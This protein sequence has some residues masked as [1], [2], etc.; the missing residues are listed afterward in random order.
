ML[1]ESF[2]GLQ[3]VIK[4]VCM[5]YFGHD[6]ED[7]GWGF[8]LSKNIFNT[9]KEVS[10]DDYNKIVAEA[11]KLG[12]R[13]VGDKNGDPILA[14]YPEPTPDEYKHM[15]IKELER[16]LSSTDWY[17]I[18]FADTGEPIP[19]EVKQKR[20]QAREEISELRKEDADN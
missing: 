10:D 7:D 2:I 8:A 18:R 1:I 5:Y 13:I 15:R 4:E 17:A 16:Y 3:L 19:E 6:N 11:Q 9:C 14:D 20:Q 12:K